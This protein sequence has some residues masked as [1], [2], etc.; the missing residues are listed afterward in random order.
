MNFFLLFFLYFKLLK[1]NGGLPLDSSL[2]L[3]HLA[4]FAIAF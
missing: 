3:E 2:L 1:V 4:I